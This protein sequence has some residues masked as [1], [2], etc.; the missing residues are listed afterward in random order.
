M[1]ETPLK[2]LELVLRTF[3]W[4]FQ[5]S[6][7]SNYSHKHSY[8][9]SSPSV[10]CNAHL[11][12]IAIVTALLSSSIYQA[13]EVLTIKHKHIYKSMIWQNELFQKFLM[14]LS[15]SIFYIESV[16]SQ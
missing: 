16:Y 3:K 15:L 12:A 8:I 2:P 10:I 5:N 1:L 13:Y 4:Q 11:L 9:L 7:V 6:N 14:H